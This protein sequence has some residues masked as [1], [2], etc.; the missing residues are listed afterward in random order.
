MIVKIFWQ[1]GCPHCPAAKA[2]G[3][4]LES[5]GA[6]VEY[7][8]IKSVDGLAEAAYFNI[9]STPSVVVADGCKEV[10]SWKGKIPEVDEI[11]GILFK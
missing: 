9:L 4:E 6:D 7:N 1:D 8:N 3:K 11:N 10:K 2:L 5:T